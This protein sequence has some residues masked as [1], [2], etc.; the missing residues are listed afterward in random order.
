MSEQ[1]VILEVRGMTCGNCVRHVETAL[2]SV[3]GV[4][5]ASVNLAARQ[6]TV[7]FVAGEADLADFK[8][9]VAE[10]GYEIL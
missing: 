2:N 9:A 7:T 5:E 3:P 10:T 6:A 1:T 4:I 8:R